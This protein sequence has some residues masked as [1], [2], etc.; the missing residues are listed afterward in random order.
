MFEDEEVHSFD[1]YPT[2][3]ELLRSALM[4][5][6]GLAQWTWYAAYDLKANDC[7]LLWAMGI[8]VDDDLLS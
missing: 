2:L 3:T 8:R 7:V 4:Q 6:N 5:N 1:D